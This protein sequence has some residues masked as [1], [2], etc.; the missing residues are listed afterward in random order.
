MTRKKKILFH[1]DFSK[2]KSGFGRN[3]KAVLSYLYQTGKYEIVEY[4]MAPLRWSDPACQ[5]V[6]WK[7]YGTIPDKDE[8]LASF[9]DNQRRSVAYGS[10]YIDKIIEIEKPDV[11]IACQDGWAFSGYWDKPWWKILTPALWTTIDSLPLLPLIR[12]NIEKIPNIWSWASFG[13]EEIQKLNH[14]AH[15]V[16]GVFPLEKFHPLKVEE[17]AF[18]RKRFSIDQDTLVFGFVFRNQLRKLVGSLLEA[19]ALFKQKNPKVKSKLIL[20]T[21]WSEG[22]SIQEF[23]KEFNIDPNDVLTT[24]VCR[25]CK[26]IDVRPFTGQGVPCRFCQAE[27][28]CHNPSIGVGCTESQLNLVY[29][30]MDAYIHPMTSG[31]LEMPIVEAMLAGVPVS[32]VPYSCGLDFTEQKCVHSISYSEYRECGSNFIKASPNIESIYNFMSKAFNRQK[33][34]TLGLEGRQWA[35]QEFSTEKTMKFIE[36][37]IDSVP[38]VEE[39]KWSQKSIVLRDENYP[40]QDIEDDTTWLLDMYSNI[41]KRDEPI[42]SDGMN[43]WKQRLA[44]GVSRNQIHNFFLSEAKKENVPLRKIDLNTLFKQ[45]NKRRIVYMI[46]DGDKDCLA[47]L[48]LIGELR[49]KYPE[50]EWDI[51]ISSNE[52]N[53]HFFEHLDG[54]AGFIPYTTQLDDFKT[55]E[56]V[57]NNFGY[58]DIVF[59]PYGSTQRFNNYIHNG[60]DKNYLQSMAAS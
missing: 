32:T 1:S 26:E 3:A 52:K 37:F 17:Q 33:Y 8:E 19:F 5:T 35:L 55:L 2:I 6:P 15:T 47:S 51:Y 23:L 54:V 58:C 38:L 50:E 40:F 11:Y 30:L 56:G 20:H 39:E 18:L 14:Q 9:D 43:H 13:T 49:N 16:H 10:L 34:K 36:D 29:N 44:Q 31:G 46:P 22:W 21:N 45:N 48:T 28:S 7:C 59:Q 60:L 42:N 25:N 12:D 4:G 24:Y 27:N 53:S 57:G 41:L